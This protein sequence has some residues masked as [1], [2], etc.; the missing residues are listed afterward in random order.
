MGALLGVAALV[1]GCASVREGNLAGHWVLVAGAPGGSAAS[2]ASP[3]AGA[4][5]P[6]S[7]EAAGI[8]AP[9]TA[10]QPLG[11]SSP[12][13]CFDRTVLKSQFGD[14]CKVNDSEAAGSSAMGG[15]VPDGNVPTP[16]EVHWFC[17]SRTV[18]R[19]V[20]ARCGGSDQFRV[21]QIALSVGSR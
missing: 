7:G 12:S 21:E 4:C 20:L 5:P 15:G 3:P 11:V 18:V 1:G 9:P 8:A 17:D 19:V 10:G 16:G 2:P 14:E 13:H 6:P